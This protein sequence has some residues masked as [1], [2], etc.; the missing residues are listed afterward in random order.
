[1]ALAFV[2]G[3][4]QFLAG[5][6]ASIVSAAASVSAGNLLVVGTR[7]TSGAT[8]TSMT[9]DAGNLFIRLAREP[10]ATGGSMIEMW[11][12]YN[13]LA[14]AT[15]QI[16]ANLSASV[17]ARAISHVQFSGVALISPLEMTAD[18]E[19]V[20]TTV[21]T[22]ELWTT[23]D[24]AVLVAFSQIDDTG[25]TWTPNAG[26]TSGAQDASTVTMMQYQI[27]SA[28][29]VGVTVGASVSG[30]AGTMR[31]IAAGF[32]VPVEGEDTPGG[33]SGAGYSR[34]RVVNR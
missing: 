30:G 9:D 25:R 2:N 15:N 10:V 7:T 14:D 31:I 18:F 13:T 17:S 32:N 12:A 33:P 24:D 16:T 28:L 5:G 20:A 29:Q 8:V 27:V 21:T 23:V 4:A 6:A 3:A 11:A 1:M 22:P 34:S 19:A 26:F